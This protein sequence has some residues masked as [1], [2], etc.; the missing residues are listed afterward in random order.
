[1]VCS[2]IE[3]CIHGLGHSNVQSHPVVL[4]LYD[5]YVCTRV[6]MCVCVYV[7]CVNSYR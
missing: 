7:C 3:V 5:V 6:C 1:M 4:E 2:Q